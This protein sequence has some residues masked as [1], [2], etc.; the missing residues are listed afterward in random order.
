MKFRTTLPYMNSR[1]RILGILAGAPVDRLPCDLW[2]T[3]ETVAKLLAHT[4]AGTE[5]KLFEQLGIDKII[6]L[7]APY[8]A[9]QSPAE[10]GAGTVEW[11]VRY[12]DVGY[13]EGSYRE[14]AL[15]PLAGLETLME[16]EAHPW[17]RDEN[18][19]YGELARKAPAAA[20]EHLDLVYFSDDMEI[21]RAH[22]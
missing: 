2:A 7:K 15:A 4:G 9:V 8:R 13:G 21:G 19:D 14:C 6:W 16:Y 22:V 18:V 11:G 10:E 20:G 3:E 1:E 17:P 5:E 12:R